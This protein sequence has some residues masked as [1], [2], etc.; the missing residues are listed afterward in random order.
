M[1]GD[2]QHR[3]GTPRLPL[4]ARS[5]RSVDHLPRRE[6]AGRHQR[7]EQQARLAADTC[8]AAA[9]TLPAA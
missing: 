3:N 2:T 6:M 8:P 9:A 7:G 5:S 4:P 1:G